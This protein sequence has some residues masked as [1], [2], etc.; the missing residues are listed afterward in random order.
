MRQV[1][2]LQIFKQKKGGILAFHCPFY[3]L[4]ITA[5]ILLLGNYPYWNG[6]LGFLMSP[7]HGVGI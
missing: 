5:L 1:N 3:L 2:K 4:F 6:I 7:T